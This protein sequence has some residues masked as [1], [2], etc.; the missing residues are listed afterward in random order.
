MEK[1]AADFYSL[2]SCCQAANSSGRS[3]GYGG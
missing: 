3:A 1:Q 2:L